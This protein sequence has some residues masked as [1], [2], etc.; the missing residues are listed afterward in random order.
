MLVVFYLLLDKSDIPLI[1]DQPEDNLDNES[2]SQI[3][4][5]FLR[6]ARTRRQIILV[7]H[8]PNLAVYADAE[9]V[10]RVW[11]DKDCGNQFRFCSG[12]IDNEYVRDQV[13]NVLEGTMP[14]FRNRRSKYERN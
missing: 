9:Q 2:I 7:T 5:P 1:L 6:E 3:L 10:I 8:N 13:V 14:A 12:G 4:V 11:I